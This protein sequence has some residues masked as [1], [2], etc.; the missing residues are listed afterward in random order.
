MILETF[1]LIKEVQFFH[2]EELCVIILNGSV[3]NIDLCNRLYP[4][5][6][7]CLLKFPKDCSILFFQEQNVKVLLKINYIYY[8]TV[9]I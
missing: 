6:T 2:V 3:S 4:L 8:I 5:L 9:S 1:N 7:E